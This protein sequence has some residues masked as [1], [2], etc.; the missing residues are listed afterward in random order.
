VL[1]SLAFGLA[2]AEAEAAPSAISPFTSTFFFPAVLTLT[3]V[4]ALV[5]AAIAVGQIG[6]AGWMP[7]EQQALWRVVVLCVPVGGAV[8]WAWTRG[9]TPSERASDDGGNA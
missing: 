5:A 6:A 4:A 1:S 2:I 3:A 9:R 8:L 7:W